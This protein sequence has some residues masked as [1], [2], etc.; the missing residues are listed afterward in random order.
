[1]DNDDYLGSITEEIYINKFEK[2]L[3]NTSNIASGFKQNKINKHNFTFV[4]KF[5][6]G[7]LFTLNF[8]TWSLCENNY[9]NDNCST[10]C[11]PENNYFHYGCNYYNGNKVC[12]DGKY[13][14]CKNVLKFKKFGYNNIILVY[15]NFI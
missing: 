6:N 5:I 12:M 13:I 3:L 14:F 2:Y 15:L 4:K 9:Y 1:M 10:Y 8:T 7:A 11:N